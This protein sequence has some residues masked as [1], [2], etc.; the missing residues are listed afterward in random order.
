MNK[1]FDN[2]KYLQLQSQKITER[3]NEFGGKLYLEFGGKLFD[4]HHASRVLPGFLPD[5]KVTMLSTMKD[6]VEVVIVISANDIAQ[7]KLR[8][9]IGITYDEDVLR[10][11]DL[12]NSR[13]LYVGSIVIS[14]F[15]KEN[16][17]AVKFQRK[18]ESH[19]IKVYRHYRIEGYPS[20]ITHIVSEKGFGK[21]DYV[22]TSRNIVVIT[23]PGPGSGKMATCLSQMYHDSVRGIKSGYAKYETFPIW[24]LPLNHP[25]NIAYEAATADLNDINMIDPWHMAAYGESAVNYNRDVEVFP[26]LNAIF[27]KVLG[28]SPYK[29]P[30]DM[31]VNMVG[32]CISDEEV[33]KKACEQEIIRR[34]LNAKV[35][36][37]KGQINQSVAD[38]LQITMSKLNL[39]EQDRKVLVAARKYQ[40]EKKCHTAA[41]ELPDGRIVCG[42]KSDLLSPAAAT[43]LN[44]IKALAGL[45][46]VNLI[47]PS[48]LEPIQKLKTTSLGDIAAELRSDEA[49]IALT[50][51]ASVNPM[52]NL[53]LEQ[54]GKLRGCEMHLSAIP[55][56]ADAKIMR[57]LGLQVTC[58]AVYSC[59]Q[60]YF[61]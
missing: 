23:A 19:G 22:E 28:Q 48:A 54:L 47:A 41:I 35:A 3:V 21:N 36:V 37:R 32:Y 9:D 8:S 31:G 56:H 43:L 51:S 60:V 38:K 5:S 13:G 11:Y 57:K 55:S 17:A 33:C 2:D 18:L 24:N 16:S 12:L 52:A 39:T 10:L 49:L 46:D 45:P 26:V 53:A 58:E 25:V 29:S 42:K 4:D 50:V 61:S 27:T 1:G 14:Q 59:S 20:D 34:Y 7:N 30:T 40:A 44:A 15:S 6:Q